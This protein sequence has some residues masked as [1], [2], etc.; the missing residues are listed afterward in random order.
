MPY[1]LTAQNDV[2]C[3]IGD[4]HSSDPL[5]MILG[6]A[7]TTS[8]AV[9]AFAERQGYAVKEVPSIPAVYLEQAARLTA[10]G[11]RVNAG[12]ADGADPEQKY[13]VT[14]PDGHTQVGIRDI[15][16]GRVTA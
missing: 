3:V 1:K 8:E 10:F 11:V 12:A 13:R 4:R 7:Y 2:T 16:S 15:I 9:V 6:R 14:G 5:W